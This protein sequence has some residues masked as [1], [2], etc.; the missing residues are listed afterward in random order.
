MAKRIRRGTVVCGAQIPGLV[1][2]QWDDDVREDRTQAD[3][4]E[5]GDPVIMGYG[6][7]GS[8]EFTAGHVPSGYAT[9]ALVIS[10]KELEVVNGVET[11]VSRTTTFT[12]VVFSAGGNVSSENR[13]ATNVKFTYGKSTTV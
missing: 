7:S 5:A 8:L 12:K 11:P 10:Y 2:A 4:E 6:G 13:G 9:S 3:D 1:N